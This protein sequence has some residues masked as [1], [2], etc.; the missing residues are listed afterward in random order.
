[1]AQIEH[2]QMTIWILFAANSAAAYPNFFPVMISHD[3]GKLRR[4]AK[5]LPQD[6]WS[7]QLFELPI[8]ALLPT[9][10]ETELISEL[11]QFHHEH[12]NEEDH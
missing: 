10:T 2:S 12:F 9:H 11:G 3:A 1:M 4:L 5:K 7:Y 8:G 6:D